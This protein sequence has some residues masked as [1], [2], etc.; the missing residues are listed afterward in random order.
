MHSFYLDK[1]GESAKQASRSL[2]CLLPHQKEKVLYDLASLLENET[3]AILRA[4][5]QDLDEAKTAGINEALLD[6]LNLNGRLES[7]IEGI[8]NIA[9]LPDPALQTLEEKHLPNGLSLK[10]V[11]IPIG[12]IGVIYE[13]RPN[14][15]IEVSSLCLKSGNGVILRGGSEAIHSNQ[16]FCDLIQKALE[17]NQ[18]P[19]ECVQLITSKDRALIKEL[20]QL[21]R[22]IDLIIPRGGESLHNLCKE[23][24]TIPVISGGM[25]VCHLFVEK[26][27]DLH[28]A[29]NV[30]VN[31]K[32]QRPAVCNALDTLLVEKEI[33]HDFLIPLIKQLLAANVSFRLDHKAMQILSEF[34]CENPS[35]F[36]EATAQD[37][38]TEW[39]SLILGI[40]VV[41]NMSEAIEHI[42][43]HTTHHSDGILTEN[44]VY[45]EFFISQIDSAAVY[46]N[47]STR[48][49]DGGEFGLGG[50]IAVSTEKI[51]ARGPMGLKELM[52]YK[53]VCKGDYHV[54][55]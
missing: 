47:A 49:T 27:A 26:S 52:T 40:K 25:G 44:P 38:F 46:V 48:F 24:S 45:A 29:L 13:A 33:A 51:H 30:I 11:S 41:D 36:I 21:N 34:K 54:R 55:K 35:Q 50:E 43:K 3:T 6:R 20:L 31:A 5:K 10:K 4:N 22:F 1:L 23:F 9:A 14:V 19:K 37:F 7:I 12:V 15:T 2:K 42:L 17:N 39:H 18:L 16:I 53:W 28:R 32:T 8:R